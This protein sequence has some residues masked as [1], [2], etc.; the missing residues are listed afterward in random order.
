MTVLTTVSGTV[1]RAKGEHNLGR[2]CPYS[3]TRGQSVNVDPTVGQHARES[4]WDRLVGTDTLWYCPGA[5]C[6]VV[7]FD[8]THEQ[9]W[10]V[11]D[12]RTTVGVK[13][14]LDPVPVCYCRRVTRGQIA[15]ELFEQG[16]C[17][18]VRDIKEFTLANTGELCHVTNPSGRC[19][20]AHLKHVVEDLVSSRNSAALKD[21]LAEEALACAACVRGADEDAVPG[22]S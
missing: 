18:S 4:T 5:G 3:G 7:Y 20:G 8:D 1:L 14:R 6:P 16:C 22:Q 13:T 15:F 17:T 21:S 19:C 11:A 10:G 9:L 2:S 12:L